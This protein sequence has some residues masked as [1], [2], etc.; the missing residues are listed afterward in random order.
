M[1]LELVP[2]FKVMIDIAQYVS[3]GVTVSGKVEKWFEQK[4]VSCS[5]KVFSSSL[6]M[7]LYA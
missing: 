2:Y 1:T 6:I 5:F 4:L 3:Y 7:F